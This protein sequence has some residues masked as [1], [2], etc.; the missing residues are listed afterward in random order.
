MADFEI[1]PGLRFVDRRGWGASAE[2]P[3]LGNDVP[4]NARTHVIIHHTV[5]PDT[6]GSPNLWE[7]DT[8]VFAMMRRLQTVRPDLGLDVPYNFVVFLMNGGT[9]IIV[10][11]GRGED[12]SG[13]HTKGHNTTGIGVCFA[14]NFENAAVD[15]MAI[16]SRMFLLSHFLGWLKFSA[17]HPSYGNFAPMANLGNLRPQSRAVF[18]HEDFKNTACPGRIMKPHAAQVRFINPA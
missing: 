13:A 7:T 11:E 18:F 16:S 3:R 6:D 1:V 12:R 9:R 15:P 17:S 4:R 2:H 14:G 10:C 5:M 8:E